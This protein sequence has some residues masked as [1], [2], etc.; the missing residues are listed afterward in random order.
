M[1]SFELKV[2]SSQW[3]LT[4][5]AHPS[6]WL[7]GLWLPSL[8]APALWPQLLP[9]SSEIQSLACLILTYNQN[10]IVDWLEDV[11]ALLHTTFPGFTLLRGWVTERK[12]WDSW[13]CQ[14]YQKQVAGCRPEMKLI[15]LSS[16]NNWTPSTHPQT[17]SNNLAAQLIFLLQS[18][19]VKKELCKHTEALL[20]ASLKRRHCIFW[21]FQCI[22]HKHQEQLMGSHTLPLRCFT[23]FLLVS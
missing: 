14:W 15:I 23:G 21:E 8:V 6:K 9:V 20:T 18:C 4:N 22:V 5:L 1:F 13:G 12:H 2:P 3:C 19:L 17:I 7:W 16:Q 11:C 10:D